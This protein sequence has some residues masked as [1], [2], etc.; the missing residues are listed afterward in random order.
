MAEV[1]KAAAEK[2]AAKSEAAQAVEA[3]TEAVKEVK[4]VKE[5]PKNETK[6]KPGRKP[7]A[8]KN[9]AEKKATVKKTAAKKATAKT[10][11]R[12]PAVKATVE[13]QFAGNMRTTEELVKSAKDIWEYDLHRD[14]ADIKT[15]EL[16]VKPEEN[17][18]YYVI[19]DEERGDFNF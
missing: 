10:P 8:A 3:K 7:A 14:P 19:N 18:V 2:T 6:K 5:A 16:Y 17:K 15:V 11:G 1:K 4:E 9:A 13:I 12:K